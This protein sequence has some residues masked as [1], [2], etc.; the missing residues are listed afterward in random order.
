[1]SGE[2]VIVLPSSEW[3]VESVRKASSEEMAVEVAYGKVFPDGEVYVRVPPE[4]K[5]KN[6]ILVQSMDSPQEKALWELL[7]AADASLNAGARH[8]IALIPYLAYARQDKVFLEGEPVSIRVLL[9]AMHAAGIEGIVTVD[10]HNPKSLDEFKGE[11]VNV[12]PI[13]E[14]GEAVKQCVENPLVIAP[15]KGALHRAKMMSEYLGAE[16]DY[17]EK[18][19]DRMTGEISMSVKEMSV[20][21]RDVV[22]VDDIIS[23]GG[24]LAKA[25]EMLYSQG[26]R[27]VVAAV[28]HALLVGNALDKLRR[29]GLRKIIATNTLR[30]REGVDYIDIM[31]TLI[32]EAR[33]LL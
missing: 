26:A 27:K 15:D 3:L 1:M 6:V 4:V 30:R 10:I 22:I 19:R 12:I 9:K 29:A 24:T 13:R 2:F 28:S 23:T 32:S 11:T 25:T 5:D 16:Y 7:L 31:P 20:K 33:K 14:L 17:I 18:K 8:V 21:G